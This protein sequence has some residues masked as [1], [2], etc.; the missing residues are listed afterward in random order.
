MASQTIEIVFRELDEN[1]TSSFLALKREG[2]TTDEASFVAALEDDSPAYPEAVRKRLAQASI[3]AGDIVL[4]AFSPELI[5]IIAITR[6]KRAKRQHKADLHGM[7]V[8]PRYRGRGLGKALLAKSLEMAQ[9]M[10]GL[11]EIQLIVAD[12]N[13]E[14]VA[15]Y[16]KVGFVHAWM[17]RRALKLKD[18]YVDAHHMVLELTKGTDK[19]RQQSAK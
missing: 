1:D 5:G 19:S 14:V 8:S 3:E 11:E 2:L 10:E 4:G 17:E 9:R 13:R 6:D 16:E 7:Y 12:H 15:L 18:C